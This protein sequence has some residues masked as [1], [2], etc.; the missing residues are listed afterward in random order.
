M[1]LEFSQQILEKKIQ[2]SYLMKICSVGA[3]LFRAGGRT[4]MTM[5]IDAFRNF[6]NLPKNA[7]NNNI[8]IIA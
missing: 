2:I 7:K 1:K 6:A 5:L 4:N 3:E 8:S